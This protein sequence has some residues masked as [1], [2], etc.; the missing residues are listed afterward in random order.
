MMA[1]SRFVVYALDAKKRSNWIKCWIHEKTRENW[2]YTHQ[3]WRPIF[4][5]IV[6]TIRLCINNL[7]IQFI[8]LISLFRSS[9]KRKNRK[10][11]E[12]K[13]V[14]VTVVVPHW[15][16][17][18]GVFFVNNFRYIFFTLIPNSASLFIISRKKTLSKRKILWKWKTKRKHFWKIELIVV[19]FIKHDARCGHLNWLLYKLCFV[20]CNFVIV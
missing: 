12:R 5:E 7:W 16:P 15:H 18:Y 19:F 4:D 1:S 2:L 6:A 9:P 10:L 11:G 14:K 8:R 3:N 13:H 17:M 20:I